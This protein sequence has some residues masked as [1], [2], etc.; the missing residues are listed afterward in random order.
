MGRGRGCE[1]HPAPGASAAGSDGL[2]PC[3][4][5]RPEPGAGAEAGHSLRDT[6]PLTERAVVDL[7]LP[8]EGFISRGKR[9]KVATAVEHIDAI[10]IVTGYPEIGQIDVV[11]LSGLGGPQTRG[12][13]GADSIAALRL[14]RR[15]PH[16][17]G[18]RPGRHSAA[19]FLRSSAA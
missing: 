18:R 16:P 19:G 1:P 4:F 6:D 11:D 8:L 9:L 5:P 12:C 14:R 3:R 17:S 13:H 7:L 2:Q 15:S 10:D